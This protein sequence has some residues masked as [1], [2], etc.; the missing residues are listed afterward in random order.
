MDATESGPNWWL[1]TIGAIIILAGLLC[2]GAALFLASGWR[3]TLCPLCGTAIP[4]Q[5]TDTMIGCYKCNWREAVE[6]EIEEVIAELV[7]KAAVEPEAEKEILDEPT[8][9]TDNLT[10]I[11]GIGLYT[12][13]LLYAAGIKTLAALAN[14]PLEAILDV[15]PQSQHLIKD[16]QRQ[17]AKLVET[18][19]I[20]P[21]LPDWLREMMHKDNE[22][23]EEE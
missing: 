23:A 17:A 14:S 8:E 20:D 15:A 10:I 18:A 11:V 2:G 4:W 3:I 1:L 7:E 13:G 12:Q 22:I 6:L 9:V 5:K 16:W 21:D 19:E